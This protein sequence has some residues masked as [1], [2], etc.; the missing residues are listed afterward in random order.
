[1]G[2]NE[3]IKE[4]E[5]AIASFEAAVKSLTGDE[6]DKVRDVIDRLKVK[7]STIAGSQWD[8][9][10]AQIS[11]DDIKKLSE[12]RKVIEDKTKSEEE[13]ADK[14]KDVVNVAKKA[15]KFLGV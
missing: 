9:Y 8:D 10:K 7:K 15:L 2:I 13:K 12:A 3:N 14:V 5:D 11:N 6:R 1:M 4:I